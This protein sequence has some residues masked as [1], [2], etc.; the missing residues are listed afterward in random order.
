MAVTFDAGSD[1]GNT[2]ITGST[3]TWAHTCGASATIL[4]VGIMARD[5]SNLATGI[6]YNS[7]A[8]TKLGS[9]DIVGDGMLEIWYLL[10]PTTGSAQNIVVTWAGSEVSSGAGSS[11]NGGYAFA[12]FASA[13]GSGVGNPTM[14]VNVTSSIGDMVVD[15]ASLRFGNSIT[16]GAG[17]TQV[18]NMTPANQKTGMSYEAGGATITMSWT[19][20]DGGL[21]RQWAIVAG[22]ISSVNPATGGTRTNF[23]S[24]LGVGT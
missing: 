19:T 3:N 16:V 18:A 23:L 7:V 14:T 8:L 13:E 17:Q 5:T 1:S 2:L 10:N 15:L 12:N 6:T 22:S 9:Q 21:G 4:I 20:D 24:L 11:Y